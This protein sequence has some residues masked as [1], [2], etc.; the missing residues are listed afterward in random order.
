MPEFFIKTQ[1]FA[2]PCQGTKGFCVSFAFPS[3]LFAIMSRL[4]LLELISDCF[5]GR[6]GAN[7]PEVRLPPFP[8][9][10]TTRTTG[11]P[12]TRSTDRRGMLFLST[13]LLSAVCGSD[14]DVQAAGERS[15]VLDFKRRDL[16]FPGL[17]RGTWTVTSVLT[18]LDL[19]YGEGP[20]PDMAVVRRAQEEDLNKRVE[21]KIR[22]ASVKEGDD[23]VVMDRKFNTASMLAMYIPGLELDSALD[24]IRWTP[25][26]PDHMTV[27][28]PKGVTITS[29][30]TRRS[31]E[32]T[33]PNLLETNEFFQQF[34]DDG[35]RVKL[36]AS[37][38]FT[39]WKWRT[40][41]GQTE[42]IAS[43]IVADYRDPADNR[44]DLPIQSIGKPVV[45]Y[46]YRMTLKKDDV[47]V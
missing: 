26:N 20:V 37:R 29:D 43:Q 47:P 35:S 41:D 16:E 22:F 27:Q 31:Q 25:T 45:L 10:R 13:S 42:I 44:G 36:K 14:R 5:P 19:P 8:D 32:E 24:R 9:P 38:A 28:L 21:Y 17:F 4:K 40:V 3:A 33:Q 15:G 11:R 34:L 30:T 7:A 1:E 12:S 23:V 2:L 46:A 6:R 39:K 18:R